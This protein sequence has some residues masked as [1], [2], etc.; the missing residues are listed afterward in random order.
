MDMYVCMCVYV[1]VCNHQTFRLVC[2][3]CILLHTMLYVPLELRVDLE[4]KLKQLIEKSLSSKYSDV[5]FK[6]NEDLL[7]S[8]FFCA[9]KAA[10]PCVFGTRDSVLWKTIFP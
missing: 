2:F 10:V 3:L 9:L 7:Y 1:C 6:N 4:N 5:F 8:S